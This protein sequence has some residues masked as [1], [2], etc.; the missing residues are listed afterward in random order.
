MLGY[1]DDRESLC[2]V[3]GEHLL[4]EIFEVGIEK[5]LTPSCLELLPELFV[6]LFDNKGV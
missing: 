4:D 5:V 1:L 2:R 3:V 6:F